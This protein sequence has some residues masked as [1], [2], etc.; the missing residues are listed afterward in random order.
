M[1]FGYVVHY[2][3][4]AKREAFAAKAPF[5]RATQRGLR[6]APMVFRS[7]QAAPGPRSIARAKIAL[8]LRLKQ[9]YAAD[10]FVREAP[11]NVEFYD[12]WFDLRE[13]GSEFGVSEL[14]GELS[15]ALLDDPRTDDEARELVQI[16]LRDR[17]APRSLDAVVDGLVRLRS[18]R[19]ARTISEATFKVEV[20][21][22]LFGVF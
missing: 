19:A 16:L 3:C 20:D 10:T 5:R 6:D 11:L 15:P 4:N 13:I 21:L 18:E 2:F 1:G 22:L 8:I 14:A 17:R 12:Q 7:P 9:L